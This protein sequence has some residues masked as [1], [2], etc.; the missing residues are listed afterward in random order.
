M[1]LKTEKTA[2]AA[3]PASFLFLEKQGDVRENE[4]HSEKDHDNR[5]ECFIFLRIESHNSRKYY[6]RLACGFASG[7]L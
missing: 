7:S 5:D 6:N 3:A 2:I 1:Y 4:S